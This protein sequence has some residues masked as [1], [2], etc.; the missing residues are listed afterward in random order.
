MIDSAKFD[1]SY[2]TTEFRKGFS[3]YIRNYREEN[4]K[5]NGYHELNGND[6]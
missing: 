3:S 4:E 6:Y 5:I 2:E 1:S